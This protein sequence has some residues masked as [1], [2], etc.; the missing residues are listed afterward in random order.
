MIKHVF[1]FDKILTFK[2]STLLIFR[3]AYKKRF[4]KFAE[5]ITLIF[6]SIITKIKLLKIN[7][8]KD[9]IFLFCLEIRIKNTSEIFS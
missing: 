4:I 6:L 2:D 9:I 3:S 5:Y 1:D 7:P 8:Y